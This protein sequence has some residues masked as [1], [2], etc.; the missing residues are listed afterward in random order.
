MK[1]S[2][3]L[4]LLL[5]LIQSAFAQDKIVKLNGDE[6][7]ARVREIKLQ[8]IVYQHPDSLEGKLHLIP[9]A[10]V[11]MVQYENGTKEMI[12]QSVVNQDSEP[13]T[14]TPEQMYELGRYDA[15]HLYKGRGAMWGSAAS[16]FVF[17]YG[18]AGSAAIGLVKPKAKNHPV[19][20]VAYLSD[21][22]YV[23]GY[24]DRAKRRKWGKVAA[25]TGIGLGVATVF[26]AVLVSQVAFMP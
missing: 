8:E 15:Q 14:R 7:K 5:V 2:I 3:L 19:S 26:I 16:G 20:D 11:F 10:E 22:N 18:L 6:I 24:E 25:G 17:P 21:P 1:Q 4:G 23:K 12:T 9:K 13:I